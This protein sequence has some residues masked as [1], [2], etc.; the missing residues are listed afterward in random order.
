MQGSKLR[1]TW[2]MIAGSGAAASAGRPASACSS[3]PGVPAPSRGEKFQVVGA[4]IW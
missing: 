4:M 3:A 1:T 2:W